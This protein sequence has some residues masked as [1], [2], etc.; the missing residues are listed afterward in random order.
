[1]KFRAVTTTSERELILA[2]RSS[3]RH[4]SLAQLSDWRKEGLLPPLASR[5]LGPT[6]GRC[7][8]WDE[9]GIFDHTQCVHD[10]LRRHHQHSIVILI[11][12]LCGHPVP[13]PKVRR[14]WLRHTRGTRSWPIRSSSSRGEAASSWPAYPKLLESN[15]TDTVFLKTILKL[16]SSFAAGRR[17]DTD[18][19]Y[20]TL[21]RASDALGYQSDAAGGGIQYHLFIVLRLIIAAIESS[22][23]LGEAKD[24]DLEAARRITET[25]TRLVQTLI[26][27]GRQDNFEVRLS[28]RMEIVGEPF[29]LCALLLQR[30][31]YRDHLASSEAA[32][33]TL[34]SHIDGHEAAD[35]H[36]VLNAFQHRL[37]DI[38]ASPAGEHPPAARHK[39]AENTKSGEARSV[40][41]SLAFR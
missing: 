21:H 17:S 36:R 15:R 2:L 9:D 41:A 6:K 24:D 29:F 26:D 28:G 20:H 39:A 13:M 22:S 32:M 8:Y 30:T 4:V 14:A 35:R 34:L 18:D 16:S 23:L 3:G 37:A 1:M 33:R 12:W 40:K 31:G 19:L 10:L 7:Y 5:G 27:E 11:L 38:W 25:A